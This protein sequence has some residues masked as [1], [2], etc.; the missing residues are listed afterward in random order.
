M[1]K[2]DYFGTD[3]LTDDSRILRIDS[4]GCNFEGIEH[5]FWTLV[6]FIQDKILV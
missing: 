2:L 4:E 1:H 5:C 3:L 6:L